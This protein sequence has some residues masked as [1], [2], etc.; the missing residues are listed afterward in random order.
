M[1]LTR[2]KIEEGRKS[3]RE[4]GSPASLLHTAVGSGPVNGR[5]RLMGVGGEGNYIAAQQ[6]GRGPG[7]STSS[8]RFQLRAAYG[9]PNRYRCSL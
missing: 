3:G 8:E 2:Q 5:Q 9:W 7:G 1:V 4:R 6:V